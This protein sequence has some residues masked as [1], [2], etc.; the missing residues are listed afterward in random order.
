MAMAKTVLSESILVPGGDHTLTP[1]SLEL[2]LLSIQRIVG[3]ET[4][5]QD[6]VILFLGDGHPFSMLF[7]WI[8]ELRKMKK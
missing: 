2:S 8:C 5:S 1:F 3:K 6:I 4:P 7:S